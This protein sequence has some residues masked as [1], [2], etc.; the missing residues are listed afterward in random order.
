LT[1]R[2]VLWLFALLAVVGCASACSRGDGAAEETLALKLSYSEQ[3]ISKDSNEQLT[4]IAIEGRRVTYAWTYSGFH[5][6]P[7]Y[8]RK[9]N[10]RA[11]LSQ[12]EL[13][14]IEE[15]IRSR[16]L[17]RTV[18]E[19]QPIEDL[20]IAVTV[21]LEVE[22]EGQTAIVHIE[23]MRRIHGPSGAQTNLAHAAMVSDVEA[24]VAQ[25][26]SIVGHN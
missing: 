17:L 5:P 18:Q 24:L 12:A 15:T 1:I 6:D 20:G 22:M 11:R 2:I 25:V 10:K 23:G 13:E 16:D 4:E 7:D 14:A 3:E 8:R 19:T 26:R 9:V 21:D